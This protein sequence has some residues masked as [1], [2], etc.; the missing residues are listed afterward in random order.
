MTLLE[1]GSKS[2]SSEGLSHLSKAAQRGR[3]EDSSPGWPQCMKLKGDPPKTPHTALVLPLASVSS[4][5]RIRGCTAM[6]PDYEP[7]E[8]RPGNL[9]HE[10]PGL[11]CG[12][13]SGQEARGDCPFWAKAASLR[14]S[15]PLCWDTEG[16]GMSD[17]GPVR[18]WA[19]GARQREA[20]L[21]A[22]QWRW[23]GGGGTQQQDHSGAPGLKRFRA[24]PAL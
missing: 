8:E 5:H 6:T 11:Q 23:R 16:P 15:D 7:F 13:L 21:E 17:G 3:K 20:R 10:A 4:H 1:I 22:S 18:T 24:S 14:A 12:S 19:L 9:P 2:W